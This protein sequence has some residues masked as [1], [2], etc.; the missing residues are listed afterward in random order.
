MKRTGYYFLLILPFIEPQLFKTA[1]FTAFD[2]LFLILKLFCAILIVVEYLVRVNV[3]TTKYVILMITTQSVTLISTI[4][5]NGS[6]KRCLGPVII[7]VVMIMLGELVF[8]DNWKRYLIMLEWY[9]R[10]LFGLH[11]ITSVLR[12]VGVDPFYT[13]KASFLG[14]ENRWIY[15]FLPWIIISSV[16]SYIHYNKITKAPILSYVCCFISLL[17]TWSVGALLAFLIFPVI[18]I[19]ILKST[20][21]KDLRYDGKSLIAF[22]VFLIINY[23][24]VTGQ[25]LQAFSHII[26]NY[27][28]KS[29]TLSG[30]VYLWEVVL[31]CLAKKPLLG[32][33]VHSTEYDIAYFYRQSGFI[34]GTAVNHPHNHLLNVAFHGGLLSLVLFLLL[35]LCVCMRIDAIK[36]KHMNAIFFAGAVTI[37][38]AA[39]VD[40][41]DFSL[42]YF[43]I[44]LVVF[45]SEKR[46]M[47]KIKI[48]KII[49][50]HIAKEC[51]RIG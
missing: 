45:F 15:V 32:E 23:V 36:D 13:N 18:M 42:F 6:L 10:F 34:P 7:A 25:L 11:I 31:N 27:L 20:R 35:L 37:F 19:G 44:P 9:F 8:R 41:L 16:N 50:E 39:L 38:F 48:D 12:I 46:T 1:G 22:V 14:I 47:K 4:I 3:H 51:C 21:K 33:G 40:T 43:L 5:N 2:S 49:S 29:I 30:R 26:I 24:L 17:A 28:H